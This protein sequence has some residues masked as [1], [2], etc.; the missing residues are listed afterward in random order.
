MVQEAT[1]STSEV[2]ST[3]PVEAAQPG[4]LQHPAF[5]RLW[6]AQTISLF[7]DQVTLLA[8]PL[9]AVL[10]L[11]A[12]PTQM[13]FLTAAGWAPHLVLSLVV[14]TWIDQRHHRRLIMIAADLARA[15]IL[16]SIPIAY[17]FN[18]LTLGQL[19]AVAFLA[20]AGSVFFDQ[21]WSGFFQTVVP[22]RLFVMAQSRLSTSRAASQVGGPS[23]AGA[24]VSIVGA[25]AAM[26]VDGA[27]FIASA[28]FLRS[29]R[30]E[31]PLPPAEDGSTFWSRTKEGFAFI[32][33][34]PL[35]RAM[36][37][38]VTVINFFNLMFTAIYVLYASRELG[39]SPGVIGL[40][41]GVGALGGVAGALLSPAAARRMGIGPAIILGSVLFPGALLI[42]PAAGGPQ[43]VVIACLLAAMFI[44]TVGV[45]FFDVN[46]NS[47]SALVTPYRL[48]GRSAG[49]VRLFGYG[50]R[51]LGALLGGYLGS[52]IGLRETMVIAGTGGLLGVIFLLASPFRTLHDEPPLA[53]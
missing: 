40:V 30:A 5:V 27:S 41:F 44:A 53:E 8:L 35:I 28:F 14:G 23:L 16:A 32:F 21:S 6:T 3:V 20:G 31:E 7:G 46:L 13:G 45:M 50:C 15:A 26:A 25:P 34:H 4:L 43:P 49:A 47:V 18:V 24:L 36:V 37:L 9:C 2:A 1:I 12:G 52:T 51:P 48:R 10:L 19:Y 11:G 42:V 22:R 29:I 17:L 39:L 38:C 33:H